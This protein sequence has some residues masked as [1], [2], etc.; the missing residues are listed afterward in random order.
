M[1]T[2]A[3]AVWMFAGALGLGACRCSSS[4][5][6]E[7]AEVPAVATT[8]TWSPGD[9][10]GGLRE[11][12]RAS[13]AGV[14]VTAVWWG[15]PVPAGMAPARGFVRLDLVPDHGAPLTWLATE[16]GATMAHDVPEVVFSPDCTRVALLR[17]RHGPY[18]VIATTDLLAYVRAVDVPARYL[19]DQVPCMLGFV[20]SDLR[21]RSATE[22]EYRSGGDPFEWHRVDITHAPSRLV[23]KPCLDS[24][25]PLYEGATRP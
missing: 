22:V 24:Q 4:R 10:A 15:A 17:D 5:T 2:R 21:W 14:G 19:D 3:L 20:Y 25:S 8:A 7:R 6:Q 18:V 1:H 11:L 23:P 12:A 9:A 13:C 16:P